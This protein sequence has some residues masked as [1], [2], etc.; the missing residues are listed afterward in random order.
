MRIR[1]L[2]LTIRCSANRLIRE[3]CPDKEIILRVVNPTQF[4]IVTGVVIWCLVC[5]L[6]L[7]NIVSHRMTKMI[8][9]LLCHIWTQREPLSH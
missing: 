9:C 3:D 6:L 2:R 7:V 4:Q 8:S 1:T 5:I